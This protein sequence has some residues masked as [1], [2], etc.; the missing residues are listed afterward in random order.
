MLLSCRTDQHRSALINHLCGNTVQTSSS[1]FASTATQLSV[2]C[3]V[4]HWLH[5]LLLWLFLKFSILSKYARKCKKEIHPFSNIISYI[6]LYT[7]I[8]TYHAVKATSWK[9]LTS[10]V[11]HEPARLPV[12]CLVLLKQLVYCHFLVRNIPVLY[13]FKKIHY[14]TVP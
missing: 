4:C 13:Q 9:L 3:L 1:A 5:L 7:Y 11:N 6:C 8:F 10:S 12:D 14:K 2:Y